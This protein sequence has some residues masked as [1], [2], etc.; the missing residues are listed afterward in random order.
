MAQEFVITDWDDAYA[1]AVHIP[2]GAAYPARWAAE[3]AAFRST[4]RVRDGLFLPDG[5]P[6][7]LAVFIHGGW[8]MQFGPDD[9]SHLAAGAVA[10]G[11]AV[12][13]AGYTLAP[14]ARVGDMARQVAGAI[15][16]AAAR[17]AGPIAIAGH[18]AGGQLCARMLCAGG[19][20][21]EA[22]LGRVAASLPISGLFDLRPLIRLA[23]NRT[24]GIDA[25]EAAAESPALLIPA[26]RAPMTVWVGADE[27]VP[28]LWQSQMMA[29]A[30]AGLGVPVR[31]VVE[32]GRHHFDVI[33]GLTRPGSAMTEAWLGRL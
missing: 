8:W 26:I 32:P 4:A 22:V 12:L 16:D 18:S 3:A 13:I 6:K 17:V 15:T 19:P 10:R 21:P 14:H 29:A 23:A 20:L 27:R 33:E 2:G 9:W 1:N 5:P 24:I 25:A 31:H 11:W 30:W 28:F 7:G